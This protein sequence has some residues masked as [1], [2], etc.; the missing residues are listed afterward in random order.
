VQ[1]DADVIGLSI[2]SGAH[3][4]IVARVMELFEAAKGGRHSCACWGHHSRSG[5]QRPEATWGG[6]GLPS[7]DAIK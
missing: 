5:H 1:E 2:L 4:A 3:D 6:G 7:W